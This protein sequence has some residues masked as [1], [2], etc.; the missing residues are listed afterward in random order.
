[1]DLN[2]YIVRLFEKFD[3]IQC[4][5]SKLHDYFGIKSTE[6]HT[7]R[8][9]LEKTN[10]NSLE[11]MLTIESYKREFDLLQNNIF[12]L[13][14]DINIY[15]NSYLQCDHKIQYAIELPPNY[16]FQKPEWTLIEYKVNDIKKDAEYTIFC[17]RFDWSPALSLDKEILNYI[18][19]LEWI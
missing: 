19:T 4:D 7:R 1:M 2:R 15:I 14:K 11:Y 8:I 3:N 5:I 6:N 12:D 9:Y 10:E 13:P 18:S 17:S 16:P